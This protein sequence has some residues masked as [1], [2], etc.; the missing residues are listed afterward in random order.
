MIAR[1]KE[2]QKVG[3]M[4]EGQWEI[5]APSYGINVMGVKGTV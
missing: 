1:E 2:G 3:K 4:G 5:Q